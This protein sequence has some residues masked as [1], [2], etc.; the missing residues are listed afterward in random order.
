M[1][2][3]RE[4]KLLEGQCRERRQFYWDR[5]RQ[6]GCRERKLDMGEDE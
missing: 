3:E 5:Y 2:A 6:T 1:R 4:G